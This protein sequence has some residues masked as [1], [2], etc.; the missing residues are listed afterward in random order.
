MSAR[1]S[2]LQLAS[3]KQRTSGPTGEII[4]PLTEGRRD[5][6]WP[7]TLPTTTSSPQVK[8]GV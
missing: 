4:K 8:L 3:H 5:S 2:A 7:K 1:I 6:D